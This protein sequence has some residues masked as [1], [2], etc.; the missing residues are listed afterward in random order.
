MQKYKNIHDL[1]KQLIR[2]PCFQTNVHDIIVEYI[3]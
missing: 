3:K 1:T 2:V